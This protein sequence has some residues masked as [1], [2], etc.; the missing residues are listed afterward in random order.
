MSD[1]IDVLAD[2]MR[3]TGEAIGELIPKLIGAAASLLVGWLIARLL[4]GAVTRLLKAVK[5]DALL[6]RAGIG[7]G[8]GSRGAELIGRTFF[9]IV[10]AFVFLGVG[11]ILDMEYLN[12]A[13]SGALRYSPFVVIAIAMV[14][15]AAGIGAWVGRLCTPWAQEHQV[16]WLPGAARAMVIGL[17]IFA[18]M[19]TL[20]IAVEVVNILFIAVVGTTAA[21]LTIAFG[22]GGIAPAREWWTKTLTRED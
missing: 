8:T 22:V 2:G 14:I 6:G 21:T 17:G 5:L 19:N 9:W 3:N 7:D 1:F 12:S 4:Q 18:A 10:M 13:I 11:E 20:Q 15:V 16:S